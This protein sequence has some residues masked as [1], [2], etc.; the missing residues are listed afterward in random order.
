VSGVASGYPMN[1][2]GEKYLHIL[3]KKDTLGARASQFSQG[4]DPL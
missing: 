2:A 1:L 4:D 3:L